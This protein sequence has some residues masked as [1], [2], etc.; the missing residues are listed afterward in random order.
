MSAEVTVPRDILLTAYYSVLGQ[1]LIYSVYRVETKPK[2]DPLIA[3]TEHGLEVA[4]A[5]INPSALLVDIIPICKQNTQIT[6][7][8]CWL[9][10]VGLVKYISAWFPDAEFQRK[11]KVW[12]VSVENIVHVPYNMAKKLSVYSLPH[13]SR[14]V[15]LE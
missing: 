4:I 14:Q 11:A 2:D 8:A 1:N 15:N 12:H 10:G 7:L 5:A 9:E 13:I 3:T 6:R